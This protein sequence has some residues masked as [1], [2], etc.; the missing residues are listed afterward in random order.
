[1]RGADFALALA[2]G[3][4]SPTGGASVRRL[5]LN[6]RRERGTTVDRDRLE[7]WMDLLVKGSAHCPAAMSLITR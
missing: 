4:R 1:M 7:D 2:Q 6:S 3:G 5:R